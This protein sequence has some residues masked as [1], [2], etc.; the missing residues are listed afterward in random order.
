MCG[1]IEHV[2]TFIIRYAW[3]SE[4]ESSTIV[5]IVIYLSIIW[6]RFMGV[7]TKIITMWCFMTCVRYGVI[8]WA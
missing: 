8:E 6:S 1:T 7:V 5:W 2:C 3:G 4:D